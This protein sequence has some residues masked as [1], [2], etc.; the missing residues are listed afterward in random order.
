MIGLVDKKPADKRKV[1][2][3]AD[4]WFRG[5]PELRDLLLK[6]ARPLKKRVEPNR[7]RSVDRGEE[8]QG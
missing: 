5:D 2:S 7:P 3:R 6:E 4:R 8:A 1:E